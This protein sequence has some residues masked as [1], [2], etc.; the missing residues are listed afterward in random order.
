MTAS[1]EQDRFKSDLL[2]G[3]QAAACLGLTAQ[4]LPIW[5]CAGR[6]SLPVVEVGRLAKYKLAVLDGLVAR[7]TL[8]G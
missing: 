8:A 2:T 5:K 7:R 3:K 6:Y 4:T 1:Y